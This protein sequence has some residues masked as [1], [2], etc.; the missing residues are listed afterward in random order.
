MSYWNTSHNG[1][2]DFKL[3]NHR[4]KSHQAHCHGNYGGSIWGCCGNLGAFSGFGMCTGGGFWGSLKAGLGFGIANGL[5]NMLFM[6]V[7]NL[8][9]GF[10]TGNFTGNSGLYGLFNGNA[11]GDNRL[12]DIFSNWFLPRRP[13]TKENDDDSAKVNAPDGNGDPKSKAVTADS[14]QNK[15]DAIKGEFENLNEITDKNKL[16]ELQSKINDLLGKINGLD[17]EGQA[18]LAELKALLDEHNTSIGNQIAALDAAEEAAKQATDDAAKKAEEEIINQYKGVGIDDP[19]TIKAL[20]QENITPELVKAYID[21]GITNPEDIIA[22]KNSGIT[23]SELG[24][25]AELLSDGSD[26]KDLANA[27]KDASS[28]TRLLGQLNLIKDDQT[29][30]FHPNYAV[31]KLIEASK[32][33]VQVAYNSASECTASHYLKGTLSNVIKDDTGCVKYNLADE[34]CEYGF[35][36]TAGDPQAYNL[37]SIKNTNKDTDYVNANWASRVYKYNAETGQLELL[38][39]EE[40]KQLISSSDIDGE[41]GDGWYELKEGDEITIQE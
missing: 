21:K 35:K 33:N 9:N 40:M 2:S 14:I 17:D 41:S 4:L 15:W 20:V 10:A 12:S 11:W 8:F 28:A 22:I 7:G 36:A 32:L 16:I 26:L 23:E 37:R 24:E 27:L 3:Y 34:D 25:L 39:P 30:K 18:T 31:L 1:I 5:T 19:E 29:V 6:G 13:K 38:N